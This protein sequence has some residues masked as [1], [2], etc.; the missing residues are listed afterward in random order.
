MEYLTIFLISM[1]G[2]LHCV[3]MCG[4]FVTVKSLSPGTLVS[5]RALTLP[6]HAVYNAGRLFTYVFLG[7]LVG[8]LGY[9]LNEIGIFPNAQA[10]LAVVSGVLMIVIGLQTLGWVRLFANPGPDSFIS[11]LFRIM[12]YFRRSRDI[13][14]ALVLGVLTGF[15]PCSLVYAFSAK[16]ASTGSALGGMKVMLAFGLGTFPAMFF[17]GTSG[18]LLRPVMR[19]RLVQVSAT[20]IVLLGV[21]TVSRAVLAT[22]PM[23]MTH[24]HMEMSLQTLPGP[25]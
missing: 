22:H 17:M 20:L 9:K 7:S 19:H 14:S 1:T 13:Y 8:A 4:G 12:A 16:A 15:L 6:W 11:P 10:A 25:G 18:L 21:I 23:D 5:P 24:H 2:S 3:G